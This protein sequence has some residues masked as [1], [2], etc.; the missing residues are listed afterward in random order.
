MNVATQRNIGAFLAIVTSVPPQSA[1]AAVVGGTIDRVSHSLAQSCVLHTAVGTVG[2][3]PSAVSVVS[4]LETSPD[5]VNWSN[6]L[7]D[8]VT[9]AQSAALTA[10]D[11]ENSLAVDLTLADRYIRVVTTPTFT[12]GTS[13]TAQVVADVVLG[14][15]NTLPAE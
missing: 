13:P 8:G 1:S 5:G 10:A 4:V 9:T 3:S 6:Y 14:G 2:G 11:T 15:E 12:G 7:P